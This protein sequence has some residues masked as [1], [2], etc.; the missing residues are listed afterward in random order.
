MTVQLIKIGRD[1]KNHI[2]IND[3]SVSR[4]HLELFRSEEGQVFATDLNSANGTYIN[5][6]K[7]KGSVI[8]NLSDVIKIGSVKIPWNTYFKSEVIDGAS[9]DDEF[10]E[11]AD[12][13]YVD[14]PANEEYDKEGSAGWITGLIIFV[15][16]IGGGIYWYNSSNTDNIFKTR[17]PDACECLEIL[18]NNIKEIIKSEGDQ[19]KL[20]EVSEK[21][22]S[23]I[24]ACDA[25]FPLP[26][27]YVECD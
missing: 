27:D 16:L 17:A 10:E 18:N 4:K 19:T 15:L 20:K 24:Q 13:D 3:E 5:G 9:V 12:E 7:L 25:A 21:Y 2:V 26:S 14:D 22:D 11:E 23:D 6:V 8:V 1:A